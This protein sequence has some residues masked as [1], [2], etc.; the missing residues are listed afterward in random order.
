MKDIELSNCLQRLNERYRAED[1]PPMRRPWLAL[2][3]LS[4]NYGVKI[5]VPSPGAKLIFEW[6][7][8]NTKCVSHNIGP[9]FK[10]VYFFD[11]S[12]YPVIIPFFVGTVSLDPMNSL[13][14]PDV[15]KHQLRLDATEWSIYMA[16]WVDCLDFA[17]GSHSKEYLSSLP[18]LG[19][20]FLDNGVK[21]LQAVISQLLETRPNTRAIIPARMAVEIYLKSVLIIKAQKD[22]QYLK[23]RIGHD[24]AKA[25]TE[26]W[27]VAPVKEFEVL[28]PMLSVFP[29]VQSRYTG[30]EAT[31]RDNWQAYCIA[32]IVASTVIRLLTGI[33]NRKKPFSC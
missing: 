13:E 33:D 10:G 7:Q 6:F 22:E 25:M 1:I 8:Q 9:L 26:C 21:E 15:L 20:A 29:D 11:A 32:Q 19:R 27:S 23:R 24:I 12:F 28:R 18:P 31:L 5:S 14:M 30:K 4:N 3:E 17:V 16:Y 2:S